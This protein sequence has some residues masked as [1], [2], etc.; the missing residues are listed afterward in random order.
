MDVDHVDVMGVHLHPEGGVDRVDVVDLGDALLFVLIDAE[1]VFLLLDQR[2]LLHIGAAD[3]LAGD[4][5]G[6]GEHADADDA[7]VFHGVSIAK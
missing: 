5:G 6:G 7:F 4:A 3:P 2:N 1:K